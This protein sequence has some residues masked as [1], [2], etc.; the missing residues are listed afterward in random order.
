MEFDGEESKGARRTPFKLDGT[1]I[2]VSQH[3]YQEMI[4]LRSVANP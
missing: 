3:L 1:L 2:I 4:E